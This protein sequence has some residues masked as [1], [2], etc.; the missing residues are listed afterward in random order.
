MIDEYVAWRNKIVYENY[1]TMYGDLLDFVNF[2]M[3]TA[4]SCLLLIEDRHIADSLGLSRS[5]FENYLLLMLMCRGNKYFLLQD[6]TNLTPAQFKIRFREKEAELAE[7]QAQKKTNCLAIRVYPRAKRHLMYIFEGLRDSEDPAYV[8]PIHFFEFQE[9]HPETMRLN[10]EDYFQYYDPG[11]A[12]K[13]ARRTHQQETT[14]RYKH[15]LSY[16]ALLQC[17]EINDL[18]TPAILARIEAH[19]TFLGKFLHP[20]HDAARDLHERSNVHDGTTAIGLGQRY[21]PAAKLLASLYVCYTVA[22]ILSE[23][24]GLFE[25][26]PG[27]YVKSAGTADLRG[28]VDNVDIEFDYF[29]F[30]FNDPPLYDRFLY[31]IHHATDEE[32]AMWGGYGNAPKE[33]VPFDQNIYGHL[34]RALGG[35]SNV[36]CG[37]YRSPLGRP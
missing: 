33:R 1:N 31:C 22:G 7:Q 10:D 4:D 13:K 18:V 12:A 5:L 19:Y 14:F 2:R 23:I 35:A 3:E 34:L 21:T 20:T 27:K 36:R 28:I 37:Q 16:D 11:A 24:A 26:A 15:Y 25:R 9:F 6:F 8:I 30:L 17:L 32:L 29:W